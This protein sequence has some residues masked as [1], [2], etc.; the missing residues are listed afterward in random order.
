[1]RK[2]IAGILLVFC[3]LLHSNIANAIEFKVFEFRN[4]IYEETKAMRGMLSDT[5]DA[6]LLVS[7]MNSCIITLTQLDAYFHILGVFETIP[8]DALA[9]QTTDFLTAWL[10]ELKKTNALQIKSL[11]SLPSGILVNTK[12]R[13]ERV[14]QLYMDLNLQL[15]QESNKISFIRQSLSVKQRR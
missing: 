11:S 13:L 3:M 9:L 8:R 4:K 2:N 10:D 1:M 12:A 5:K 15:D 7:A 14:L 6:P